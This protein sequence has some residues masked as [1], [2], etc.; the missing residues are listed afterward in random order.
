MPM[1]A[2]FTLLGPVGKAGLAVAGALCTLCL[3]LAA[4]RLRERQHV[5]GRLERLGLR[6]TAERLAA[7][8]AGRRAT[9]TMAALQVLGSSVVPSSRRDYLFRVRHELVRAGVSDRLS[10][11]Q[12][13]GLR[14]VV[15]LGG[16]GGAALIATVAG[17]PAALGAL[18]GA[19]VGA[20]LP[21]VGLSTLT[22]QRREAIERLL[23]ATIDMLAVS[24]D[25]GLSFD[26][27]VTFLCDRVDNPLVAELRRYMSDLWLG[28]SRREALGGLAERTQSAALS[29]FAAAVIQAD[30]LGTG[31]AR[32]LRAQARALRAR[33]RA[34]AEEQA[35]K[36][37]IKLLFPLILCIMPVLL[38]LIMGPAL[39]EARAIFGGQ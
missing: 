14:L 16:A 31:L 25:A 17:L 22:R 26:G 2:A 18:A 38:M 7:G 33:Q 19:V 11:E 37:P 15:L 27:A 8:R 36:A 21:A 34:R 1:D 3:A 9:G 24:L 28:R 13:L 6:T 29:E 30:E 23:P 35:R 10:P 5:G 12:F 39:L 4:V 32:T 20:A